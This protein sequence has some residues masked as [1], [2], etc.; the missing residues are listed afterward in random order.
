MNNR[1]E[2]ILNSG[3]AAVTVLIAAPLLQSC[4]NLIRKEIS[5]DGNSSDSEKFIGFTERKILEAAA[6]APSGH[7]TQPWIVK[8]KPSGEWIISM[9]SESLLKAVDPLNHDSI[10]SLGA[11]ICNLQ[12]AARHYGYE[13]EVSIIAKDS[14]SEDMV[15]VK[16]VKSKPSG[17]NLE[18]L[19]LRRTLR[20]NFLPEK[21]TNEHF[22]I[23]S[24]HRN[25]EIA[26]FTAGSKEGKYI[27]EAT[28][29]ANKL[30]A[31]RND[32]QS[33]L[34]DWI[35]WSN[36]DAKKHMNGLTPATMEIDGF[37][38]FYVRTFF[39]RDSVL[40]EDFRKKGIEMVEEQLSSF[41]GWIVL[42]SEDSSVNSLIKTG[43]SL[44]T[45]WLKAS[46]LKIAIHPMTQLLQ[47]GNWKNEISQKL[48]I[49]GEVQII[50]RTGYVKLYPEPVSLRRP[51]EMFTRI[52]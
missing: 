28:L 1:R 19:T 20:K 23:L 50:L 27:S 42:S 12:I 15:E 4:G 13:A 47:E 5:F 33:E 49:P 25:E 30:Q 31:S 44:Q 17:E 21:I 38:G 43:I 48:S 37:A 52:S 9:N 6:L 41:G 10:I 3:K 40:S 51:V 11:F 18:N 32:A 24:N 26:F 2:F 39:S 29:E 36:S 22:N 8:I 35:R 16:L 46:D 45:L 7:N 14:F 34:A